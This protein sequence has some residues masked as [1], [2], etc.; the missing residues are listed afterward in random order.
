MGWH[1]LSRAF[2]YLGGLSLIA[3]ISPFVVYFVA[4]LFGNLPSEEGWLDQ[5]FNH[6]PWRWEWPMFLIG[7]PLVVL[8][9]ATIIATGISLIRLRRARPLAIGELLLIV[10]FAALAS[11][12]YILWLTID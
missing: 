9:I 8:V 7:Y 10:Q 4:R 6:G 12:V 11:Q 3:W 1:K 5:G 2:R